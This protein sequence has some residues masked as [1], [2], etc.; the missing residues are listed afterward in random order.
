MERD[1]TLSESESLLLDEA[2]R[3]AKHL[4][5]EN[6]ADLD[7]RDD[8]ASWQILANGGFLGLA[9]P[10]E[11]GGR[12]A[13][14]VDIGL[15]AEAFGQH[16]VP[17]PFLGSVLAT[18][19]LRH[20]GVAPKVVVPVVSG[21]RRLAVGL[22]TALTSLATLE[23]EDALVAFDAAGADGVLALRSQ[24]VPLLSIV[25][26]R[27]VAM[28]MQ[29]DL[30]R[31]TQVIRVESSIEMQ[32]DLGEIQEP[33]LARWTAFAL[34]LVCA[35]LVGVMQGALNLAVQYSKIREQFGVP[36][37]SFQS[38]Q[39]L[40]AEQ[41]VNVEASRALSR[42]ACWAAD[43]REVDQALLAAR[44]AKAYCSSAARTVC[45]AAI[46]VHGG[47][48]I[49]WDCMAHVFLKRALLDREILGNENWQ[50]PVVGRLRRGAT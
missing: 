6:V 17:L 50:L 42:Y 38:I 49:T 8:R 46:Q 27:G 31:Q 19:L 30:T 11:N 21:Q 3:L 1:L 40:C 13:S 20:A 32:D 28:P 9:E 4:G 34:S 29:L 16:L 7:V 14:A 43:N 48:G 44:T 36:I 10:D 22:N 23:D 2:L 12:T 47:M 33:A 35:D 37:G 39:H 15:I 18:E 25:Q 24:D 41:H 5:L 45:E 26:F